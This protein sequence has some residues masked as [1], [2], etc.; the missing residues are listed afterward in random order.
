MTKLPVWIVFENG[1]TL[2]SFF[3]YFQVFQSNITILQ[4]IN[5]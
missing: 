3:V 4:Q 5:V 2:A 1:P